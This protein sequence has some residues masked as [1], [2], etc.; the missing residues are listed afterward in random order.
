MDGVENR[1]HILKE[2]HVGRDQRLNRSTP[3]RTLY[4]HWD[5]PAWY[6][7][8]NYHVL[9]AI[10][11]GRASV[12]RVLVGRITYPERRSHTRDTGVKARESRNSRFLITMKGYV[13]PNRESPS[14]V[15]VE[16]SP[17]PI[18]KHARYEIGTRPRPDKVFVRMGCAGQDGFVSSGPFFRTVSSGFRRRSSSVC[19]AVRVSSGEIG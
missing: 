19:S 7:V 15:D 13:R 4:I 10:S 11:E 2:Q 8:S 5:E 18:P 6:E 17:P 16:P 1:G 9:F 14:K 3:Q 12:L